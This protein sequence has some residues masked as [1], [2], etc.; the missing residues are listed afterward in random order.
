MFSRD[1]T[2]VMLV[3]QTSP[4]GVELYS[5]ANAFV[6]SNKC[7]SGHVSE[8]ALLGFIVKILINLIF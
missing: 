3:S 2:A 5:Y 4:V 6:C 7:A 1:V 8:N